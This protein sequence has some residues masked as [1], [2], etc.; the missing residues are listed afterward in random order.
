MSDSTDCCSQEPCFPQSIQQS[1]S[2]SLVNS[3]T[4]TEHPG[5]WEFE[6]TLHPASPFWR[7]RT[8]LRTLMEPLKKSIY[9]VY[10]DVS[11]VFWLT[12]HFILPTRLPQFCRELVFCR[13]D[14]R[15][16]WQREPVK[17]LQRITGIRW[18]AP[19]VFICPLSYACSSPWKHFQGHLMEAKKSL[20]AFLTHTHTHTY[21]THT[22]AVFRSYNHL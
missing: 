6:R 22:Q 15:K 16:G 7:V 14:S 20:L 2:S 21:H 10:L 12:E 17:W 19:C 9:L 13:T 5:P 8:H 4:Q 11:Q 3:S 18:A 1:P